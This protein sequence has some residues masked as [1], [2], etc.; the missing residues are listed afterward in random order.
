[1][2][3]FIDRTWHRQYDVTIIK[4][5]RDITRDCVNEMEEVL[6]Y[7]C[8]VET[9]LDHLKKFYNAKVKELYPW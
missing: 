1:M 2:V 5:G 7:D 9:Y 3:R 6:G 4:H 8:E